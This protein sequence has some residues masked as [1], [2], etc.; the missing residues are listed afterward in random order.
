MLAKLRECG[1]MFHSCDTKLAP[2]ELKQKMFK[3]GK[4]ARIRL[5]M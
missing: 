5:R 4:V 3:P 2:P 1:G